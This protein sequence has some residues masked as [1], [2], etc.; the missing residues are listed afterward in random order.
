MFAR[1]FTTTRDRAL[2]AFFAVLVGGT[3]FFNVYPSLREG[4]A[5]APAPV[6][7]A[8]MT[9]PGDEQPASHIPSVLN[10]LR[11]APTP[12]GISRETIADALRKAGT[13][14]TFPRMVEIPLG[15]EGSAAET[16][17]LEYGFEPELQAKMEKLFKDYAPDYGAFVAMDA[18]TGRVLSLVSFAR[19][20][21]TA[22]NMALRATFPSA[23]VFKVVTA[24]AVIA[25]KKY[26]AESIVPFDGRNHTLFRSN[27][28]RE[29]VGKWTRFPTLKE[30]FSHSINT[31]FGKIGALTLGPTEL[32]EYASRFGFNR[33][34][35]SDLPVEESRAVIPQDPWGVAESASGYTQDNTMSPLQGAL[36]AASVVNDGVMMA[37]YFVKNIYRRDGSRAYTA[38]SEVASVAMDARTAREMR[39][40]MSETVTKGTSRR[41]FKGFF[42]RQFS[43]LEVG[44]KTGSLT[45]ANPKGKYDW[46]VGYAEATAEGAPTVADSPRSRLAFAVLTIHEKQWRVKSSQLA[47]QAI[48]TY[49][50]R[51]LLLASE[52]SASTSSGP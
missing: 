51:K 32:R 39:E 46:F 40:L 4:G 27:V 8:R 11:P 14:G 41:S 33:Q 26:S 49:Y 25:E 31:V 13:T 44:G 9:T 6:T 17:I 50:G 47:R 5:L 7:V 1:I 18:A 28:F 48:E 35:A 22:G 42:R 34:I 24:A 43:R 30:A 3:L 15:G 38:K 21:P 10:L 37:P 29:K 45:G 20:N 36:I 2:A 12:G 19:G 52:A 16:A 23:S